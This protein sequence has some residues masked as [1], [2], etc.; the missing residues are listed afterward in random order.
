L[1]NS[2]T[3]LL[4]LLGANLFFKEAITPQI[5]IGITLIVIGTFLLHSSA[6]VL[7]Q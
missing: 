7:V 6:K 4:T 2:G 1:N 5:I 3:I